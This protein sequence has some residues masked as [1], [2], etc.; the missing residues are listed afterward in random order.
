MDFKKHVLY[1]LSIYNNTAAKI[2]LHIDEN[3]TRGSQAPKSVFSSTNGSVF[4]SSMSMV[5]L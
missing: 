5:T 3:A 2:R 4:T 1:E